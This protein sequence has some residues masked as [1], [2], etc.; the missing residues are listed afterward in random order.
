MRWSVA[1]L[2]ALAGARGDAPADFDEDEADDYE[3]AQA[4]LLRAVGK[5]DG[6]PAIGPVGVA[7]NVLEQLLHRWF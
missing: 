1:Q 4:A 6:E 7:K 5:D 3:E 2:E